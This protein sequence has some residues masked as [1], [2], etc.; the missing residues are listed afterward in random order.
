MSTLNLLYKT[1]YHIN[2]KIKIV[3][4]TLRDVLAN[5]DLYYQLVYLLTA[6]P[7]DMMVQLED[8]GVDFEEINDY[9]LF[10][11]MSPSL[12]ELD[13]SLIFG[14]LD[15]SK[16]SLV[17][18][19]ETEMFVL[20]DQE[21]GA[22]ID[23]A[24]QGQIAAVLRKIHGLEKN[25]RRPG[26]KEAREYMM[27]QARKK[28]KRR[29]KRNE[30]SSIEQMIIALVNTEQFSYRFD[31]VLDLTIYQFNESVKQIVRKIDFD[32]KMHGIYAG[33]L[34]AKH[35]SQ[36]ELNWLTHSK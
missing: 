14:D 16:F 34:D 27:T 30:D 21:S 19:K 11:L 8:I 35:I 1:E 20:R 31:N 28:I 13:T 23:R 26:N 3:I 12:T 18:N 7:I 15:F 25:Y 17:L 6:M 36:S 5:E 24:I 2:D 10:L 33:T 22:V 4:P 29:A 9:E 32:N